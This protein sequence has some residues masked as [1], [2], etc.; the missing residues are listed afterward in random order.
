[1]NHN[2]DVFV[3]CGN[4]CASLYSN[5]FGNMKY[6]VLNINYKEIQ[7]ILFNF[8]LENSKC[9]FGKETYNYNF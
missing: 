3:V 8:I 6:N 7:N 4:V 2:L 5:V 9:L 1:M